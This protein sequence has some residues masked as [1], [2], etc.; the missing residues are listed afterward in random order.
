[1][2]VGLRIRSLLGVG[3]LLLGL[4]SNS[5]AQATPTSSETRGGPGQSLAIVV[6]K[7][8]PIEDLPYSELRKIFLGERSHWPSGR[9]IAVAM[10][11]YGH[12]ERQTVLRQIYRMDENGYREH[13]IKGVFRG[14]VFVAP[15]TLSSPIVMRKFVFNAPGGIGYLRSTDVDKSVKVLRVDG[16]LPDDKDYKLLID[17]RAVE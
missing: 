14:D 7:S 1:M 10:M 12:P 11:D 4:P 5:I 9:R 2:R 16:R 3:V 15:K 13:F 17:D 8:N 6:N